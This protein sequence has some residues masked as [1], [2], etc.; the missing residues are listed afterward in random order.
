MATENP[1]LHAPEEHV[2][3]AAEDVLNAPAAELQSEP[4]AAETAPDAP[5]TP[6]GATPGDAPEPEVPAASDE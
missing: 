3:P 5:E 4:A 6:A 1:A 2:S